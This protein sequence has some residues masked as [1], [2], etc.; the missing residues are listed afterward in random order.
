MREF[1]LILLTSI[2]SLCVNAQDFRYGVEDRA[3]LAMQRYSKDTSANA[4]VLNEYGKSQ[5]DVIDNYKAGLVFEHHVK[6]KIFNHKGFGNGNVEIIFPNNDDVDKI[7]GV[8]TYDDNGLARK[9]ELDPAKI[10]RVNENKNYTTMRFAMPGLRDGCIIEYRYRVVKPSL[11]TFEPWYFQSN[12]PKIHSEYDAIIPILWKYNTSL[13]GN[14]KI[15]R[16]Q[17]NVESDC[18]AYSNKTC[19]CIHATY[20]MDDI[21]AFVPEEYMTSAKNYLSAIYYELYEYTDV[22]HNSIM[23][24]TKTW[25]NIDYELKHSP[26]FGSEIKRKDLFKTRIAPLISGKTEQLDKAKAVYD[27]IKGLIKW[28]GQDSPESDDGINKAIE[29]HTGNSG[30]INLALIAALNAAGINAEAVLLSTREYGFINKLYPVISEFNYVIGKVDI[31]GKT[32]LLD[33]TDPLLPFGVLP[34]RCLN[35]QGRVIS[36][37]KQSYWMDINTTGQ[38]RSQSHIMDL[39]LQPDGKITGTMTHFSGSYEA[40]EKRKE[41]K[42]YN[43]V[44]EYVESMDEK[45]SKFK[46]MNSQVNNLDSLDMPLSE[47]YK[48][49]IK[50][51]KDVGRGDLTFTPAIYNSLETNPFKS[52]TRSSPIDYGMPST[53]R[54]TLTLHLPEGYTIENLPPNVGLTLPNDGGQFIANYQND[55]NVLTFSRIIQLNKP[56]YAAEEYPY[57]KELCNKIILS[58]NMQVTF[59]KKP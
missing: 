36:F 26:Y 17:A 20:E 41:I 16:T 14:L 3:A 38:K 18:F 6:V 19:D 43:S 31:D 47:I 48:I 55:G 8:T 37:D 21:P 59:K 57:L 29:N 46:I 4:V 30:D 25:D 34:F 9:I 51:Y 1:V 56:V 33:A 2:I 15:T 54:F 24:V 35:D 40:Y 32:Y 50:A 39:T 58:Q 44:D 12:I 42:K 52:G 10:Y 23:R 45:L 28:D 49:E 5:I 53:E 13:R 7:T 22:A 27:Y 11:E